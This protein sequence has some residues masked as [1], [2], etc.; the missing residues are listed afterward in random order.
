MTLLCQARTRPKLTHSQ[1]QNGPNASAILLD[2][3]HI[4]TSNNEVQTVCRNQ[5]AGTFYTHEGVLYNPL[6]FALL[7]DALSHPGPGKISRL[8]L[9]KVCSTYLTEGLDLTEFLLSENAIL[10]AVVTVL[11]YQP[12][13]L[14]EPAIRREY[15]NHAM[16]LNCVSAD[17]YNLY[18]SLR[19]IPQ[20]LFL[21]ATPLAVW[22]FMKK[23]FGAAVQ[24]TWL[25]SPC[26]LFY[27]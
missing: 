8:D 11:T 9:G 22:S 24:N 16:F 14:V 17:S 3:H 21:W 12:G 10:G 27:H 13:T 1:P 25:H 4:G 18:H 20:A 7:K 23:I 6:G 15:H 2:A 26:T 19:S 5:A